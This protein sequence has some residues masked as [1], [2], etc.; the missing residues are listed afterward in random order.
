MVVLSTVKGFGLRGVK[1]ESQLT[2]NNNPT[3]RMT[4]FRNY[5][6]SNDSF[7]LLVIQKVKPQFKSSEFHSGKV[8]PQN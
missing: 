2:S 1:V 5:E 6:K 8:D 4:K 7:P 3:G